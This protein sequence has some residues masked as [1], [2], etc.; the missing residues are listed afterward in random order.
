MLFKEV[1]VPFEE[2]RQWILQ[3]LQDE[4][5]FQTL[6]RKSHFYARYDQQN[7]HINL[8]LRTGSRSQLRENQI[9]IIFERWETG[10]AAERY[11]TSFYT[12][13][14]WPNTPN[15]IFA[16]TIPAIIRYW[17]QQ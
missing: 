17:I 5:E 1:P 7:A 8:R 3:N 10:T 9:Q 16:P 6:G 14:W 12:D 11:R 4:Q 15:R 13:P 2:F